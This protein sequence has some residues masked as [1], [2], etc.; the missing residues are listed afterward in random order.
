M[1]LAKVRKKLFLSDKIVLLSLELSKNLL[2]TFKPGQFLKI[3]F[4]CPSYDPLVPRPFTVHYI[5]E[6]GLQILFQVI[7]KGTQALSEVREG[8]RLQILGPLGRP[9]PQELDYPLGLCAGGLGIAGFAF[10]LQSLS[11]ELREKTFL[12]YGARSERDLVRRELFENLTSEI[13]YATEDGSLGYRG[14][15][16]E[17]LEEDL[18]KGKI[19]SLLA[20][21]PL[22]MLKKIKELG[23]KYGVKT[24]LSLETF[25][26]CGTGFCL[27][28]VIPKRDGGYF[29]LCID[30]PTL[31]GKEVIL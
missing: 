26:A 4:P 1:E 3:K 24:F 6:E 12:Y 29:H 17:P 8:Q 18:K 10:F 11:P 31:P 14:F 30:G 7:G 25:L 22:G 19:K 2:Q 27:G 28:C 13:I 9:F 5:E 23:E 20:C 21:G 16:T 15:I